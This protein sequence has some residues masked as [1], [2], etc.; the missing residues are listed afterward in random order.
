MLDGDRISVMDTGNAGYD[1][2]DGKVREKVS[3]NGGYTFVESA[4]T[5]EKIAE[6]LGYGSVKE[7]KL[8]LVNQKD[9]NDFIN[10]GNAYSDGVRSNIASQYQDTY[11]KAV[12]KGGLAGSMLPGY[13]DAI[14]ARKAYTGQD[15]RTGETLPM[16]QRGLAGAAMFLPL[17][18]GATVRTVVDGG[19][20]F[21]KNAAKHGDEAIDALKH[22]EKIEDVASS[23][24]RAPKTIPLNTPDPYAVP[25]GSKTKIS[26]KADIETTRSLTRE[27]ESADILA[28]YGYDIE[29]NPKVAGSKNPDYWINDSVYDHYAPSAGTKPRSIWSE[30]ERK[31]LKGQTER[32]VINLYDWKGSMDELAKQFDDWPIEGLRDIILIDES[33]NILGLLQ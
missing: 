22:A 10:R 19:G 16:W 26:P 21:L 27:N 28:K 18:G 4:L 2:S 33:G 7:L 8:A 29:Q 5:E 15:I 9:Y 14:D 25:R 12:Q 6:L 24:R 3:T 17:V 20:D 30:V 1:P 11:D 23:A 31:I 32:V 13:G